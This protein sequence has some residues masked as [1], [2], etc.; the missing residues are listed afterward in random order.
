MES[1]SYS[2]A[3]ILDTSVSMFQQLSNY[4]LKSKVDLQRNE[5]YCTDNDLKLNPESCT[6]CKTKKSFI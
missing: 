4:Q 3:D 2:A 6:F 1:K 5:S